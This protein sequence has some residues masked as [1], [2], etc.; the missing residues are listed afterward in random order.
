MVFAG[1]SDKWVDKK[2]VVVKTE[3]KKWEAD[4]VFTKG[5][6]GKANVAVIRDPKVPI[7]QNW[8]IEV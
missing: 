4:V 8:T 6:D 2:K 5:H 7:T 3:H 1:V